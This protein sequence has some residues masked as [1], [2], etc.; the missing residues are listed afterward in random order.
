MEMEITMLMDKKEANLISMIVQTKWTNLWEIWF[1]T[2]KMKKKIIVIKIMFTLR[3]I[4]N[5]KDKAR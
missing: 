1:N 2:M 4:N 3:K 5:K